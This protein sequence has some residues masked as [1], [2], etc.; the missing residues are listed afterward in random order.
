MKG[1]RPGQKIG[2]LHDSAK[3]NGSGGWLYAE[4]IRRNL[5]IDEL[6]AQTGFSRRTI[7]RIEAGQ[8]A[9]RYRRARESTER[10]LRAKLGLDVTFKVHGHG[11]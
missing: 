6:A 4:R 9:T 1:R 3:A 7:I 8:G 2:P 5:T 10:R 11:A